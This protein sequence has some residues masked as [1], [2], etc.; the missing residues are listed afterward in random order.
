MHSPACIYKVDLL[1][2]REGTIA[3]ASKD[4]LRPVAF[5]SYNS[6]GL[7]LLAESVSDSRAAVESDPAACRC[8]GSRVKKS[9]AAVPTR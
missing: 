3:A 6:N 7:T 4:G 8:S 1:G 9:W 2:F 5:F